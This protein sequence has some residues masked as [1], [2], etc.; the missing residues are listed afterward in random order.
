MIG[1]P[2]TKTVKI[3]PDQVQEKDGKEHIRGFDPTVNDAL[4]VIVVEL[5]GIKQQLIYITGEPDYDSN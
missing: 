5:K 3:D 2:L 1:T 4:Q